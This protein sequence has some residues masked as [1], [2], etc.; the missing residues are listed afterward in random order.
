[1]EPQ[2]YDY[3]NYELWLV[4]YLVA[5]IIDIADSC[6]IVKHGYDCKVDI[7]E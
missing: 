7:R 1:M 5:H 2:L 3:T 4:D 6:Q